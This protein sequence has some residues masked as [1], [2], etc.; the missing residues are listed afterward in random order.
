MMTLVKHRI[1]GL[2]DG[3]DRL[4]A[5]FESRATR[6]GLLARRALDR[7]VAGDE[8]LRTRLI[9][10]L[11]GETR[12]DGSLGGAVVPT[13]WRVIELMELGHRRDE[14]GV[15]RVVGWVLGLQ[16]QPGAFGQGCDEARH[17]NKVCEHFVGGFFSP[18]LPS[19]RLS[20][21]SLPS[22]KVFRSEGA[23]R[24]AVSCLALRAS[25]M[26]GHDAR[27][28]VRKHLE[29]LILLRETSTRWDGYFSPDAI[30]SALG[31]LAVAPPPFRDH[32]PEA[33]AFIAGHQNRDGT[34]PNADLFHV[35]DHL[36]AAGTAK[37]KFAVCRAV[38]A[39]LEQQR[40]D[41]T[42]GTTAQEERAL[43]GLRAFLWARTRG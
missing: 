28:A 34:W 22:G 16:D 26:A 32:I 18:A 19:E 23:A 24:F 31:P 1:P 11:R 41:G 29:S 9:R 20:P 4:G 43:I 13:I 12:L 3:I 33:A 36:V 15:I 21:V 39:L 38:P 8:I 25:L 10:E 35:L 42:F 37:A 5:F 27:P 17:A 6:Q 7:L 14:A 2:Q 30:V 40:S